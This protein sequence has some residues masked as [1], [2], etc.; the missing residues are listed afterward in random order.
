MELQYKN[1][2]QKTLVDYISVVRQRIKVLVVAGLVVLSM[3]VV[4]AMVLPAVYMSTAVILIE[5]QDVPPDLVRSTITSY[6]VQRIEEIKQRIM[7]TANVMSIVEQYELLDNKELKRKTRTE[8]FEDFKDRVNLSPISA[9]VIDPRSGRPIK[10]TIAFKL[11]YEGRAPKKVHKVVNELVSLYL[12]ENLRERSEQSASTLEFLSAE[13]TALDSLLKVQESNI[14]KFKEDNS[15]SLPELREYNLT[16]LDRAERGLLDVKTRIQE[17]D[18]REIELSSQLAQMSPSAPTIL[19]NGEAVLSEADRLKALQSDYRMKSSIYKSGHPDLLRLQREIAALLDSIGQG[20]KHKDVSE[21]LKLNRDLL[22]QTKDKY[23][24]S[25]PEIRRLEKII[26][27]L[28]SELG[29]TII[30][31]YEVAPDNPS[32]VLLDTQLKSVQTERESLLSK[33]RELDKRIRNQEALLLKAPSVE[34]E[35][36]SLIREY[37]NTRLKYH[38]IKAKQME[39]DLA[40]NLE[41]ERKGERFT[42]VQPPE[43]PEEPIKPNRKAL[44]VLSFILAIGIGVG[45]VFFVEAIDARVYGEKALSELTGIRVLTT[46]PYMVL[47]K[48]RSMIKTRLLIGAVGAG[49]I[50]VVL[51]VLFHY[52][53]KP[54]DVTWFVLLR[55]LG[56]H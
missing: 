49:I 39:A 29:E 18:S 55:K 6:A 7:T 52:Y 41:Q 24:A 38:E 9:D 30:G 28:E 25:H 34:K 4:L 54:L 44:V 35:Y 17:L 47:E 46:V 36:Q 14:S 23:T 48:E 51:L 21:Q 13:V 31:E 32:Y 5:E 12:N 1:Q 50:L 15:G 43:I 2:N 19:P 22:S 11:T 42:L 45:A 20:N 26:A 37:D 27:E 53:V 3:G 40:K 56:L 16:V 10:A 8:I 33:S